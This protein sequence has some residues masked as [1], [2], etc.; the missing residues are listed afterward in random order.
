MRD[1][2]KRAEYNKAYYQKHKEELLPILRKRSNLWC[3]E[4]K[5]YRNEQDRERRRNGNTTNVR[6]T[7]KYRL[8]RKQECISAYG[9][10]CACC[11][12][13]HLEMLTIDHKNNNG[14]EHRK[15][16]TPGGAAIYILLRKLKYPPEYQCLC[17]NCNYS[18]YLGDGICIHQREDI[19]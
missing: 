2:Q 11:G 15:T 12:E 19:S 5:D 8:K 18:R 16:F 17:F 6:G 4:N 3:K 14:A 7:A 1:K 13:T 10:K 9:G